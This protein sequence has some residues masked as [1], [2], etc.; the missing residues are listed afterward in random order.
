MCVW[1]CPW[2]QRSCCEAGAEVEHHGAKVRLATTGK[3]DSMLKVSA[4]HGFWSATE[5]QLTQM[6]KD[7]GLMPAEKGFAGLLSALVKH[8]LPN[9]SDEELYNIM[10]MRNPAGKSAFEELLEQ[11]QVLDFVEKA[12]R[13][14]LE[15]ERSSIE[16]NK[17]KAKAFMSTLAPLRAKVLASERARDAA[18][19]IPARVRG[20][21]RHQLGQVTQEQANEWVPPGAHIYL[22]TFNARWRIR[23]QIGRA[24]V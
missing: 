4:A 5:A 24:H 16:K 23:W 8:A 14:A 1:A 19:H 13:E 9:I 15:K 10:L 18:L 6:A 7:W 17:V 12:D 2:Y 11:E 3:A 20:P 21:T 22:D